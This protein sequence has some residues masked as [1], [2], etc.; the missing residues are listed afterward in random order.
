MSVS[1]WMDSLGFE[2]AQKNYDIVIVG[3]GIAG[4]STYYWLKKEDPTLKIAIIDKNEF[5]FGAS[6]RNAGFI[7]CGSVEYFNRLVG[8]HGIEKAIEIWN[9]SEK[10][11]ELLTDEILNTKEI[12]D[13][14]GFERKGSFS[15]A[16][17]NEELKELTDS[18][19]IMLENKIDVE[20]LDQSEV[21]KRLGVKEF[22]GGIKYVKDASIHPL[23]LLKAIIEKKRC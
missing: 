23:K 10:N 7:T 15:L 8:T 1:Y 2:K 22:V 21:Q 20:I 9:F 12:Q 13:E 6:G 5:G 16:S 17:T 3:A 18:A 4:L 14:C 19:K 11:L